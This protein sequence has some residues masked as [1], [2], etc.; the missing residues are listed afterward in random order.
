MTSAGCQRVR[1]TSRSCANVRVVARDDD[2]GGLELLPSLPWPASVAAH[3]DALEETA[4]AR[5]VLDGH[6]RGVA[7]RG[8]GLSLSWRTPSTNRKNSDRV[9]LL[10]RTRIAAKPCARRR[11]RAQLCFTANQWFYHGSFL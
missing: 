2:A 11:D 7:R 9:V 3:K 8:Q 6:Q 1:P 4:V 5:A 10:T